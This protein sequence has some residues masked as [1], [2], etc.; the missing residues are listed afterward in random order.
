MHANA[1][2]GVF[3]TA[4]VCRGP[5]APWPMMAILIL[6]MTRVGMQDDTKV[7]RSSYTSRHRGENV[8]LITCDV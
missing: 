1:V 4:S 2:P 3:K 6:D 8:Y 7:C 5:I